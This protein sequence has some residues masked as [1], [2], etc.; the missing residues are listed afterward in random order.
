MY[1]SS[2]ISFTCICGEYFSHE[3]SYVCKSCGQH[4]CCEK[5]GN[6]K[7]EESISCSF[8]RKENTSN[9]YLFEVLLKYFNITRENAIDIWRNQE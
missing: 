5:C 9:D 8:C 2:E 7:Y 6:F 1:E 3:M 4:Y